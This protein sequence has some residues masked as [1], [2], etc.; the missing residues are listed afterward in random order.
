MPPAASIEAGIAR[1]LKFVEPDSTLLRVWPLTGGI[2]SVMTAFMISRAGDTR[3]LVLRQPGDWS[4]EHVPDVTC[5]EFNRLGALCGGGLPVPAPIFCAPTGAHFGRPGLVLEYI[6]GKP[7]LNPSDPSNY[8]DQFARQLADIHGFDTS[9]QG[10]ALAAAPLHEFARFGVE[11]M[12]QAEPSFQVARSW[13]TLAANA[14]RQSRNTPV[15][16]HGDFWPGNT[17]WRDGALV[18][19]IDWENTRAGD[20]LLDLSISR[21]DI[22]WACGPQAMADFTERY[23]AYHP[24]DTALLPLWDLCTALRPVTNI[25]AWAAAYGPL[26]RPDITADTMRQAHSGFVS[27]AFD[28]W[29]QAGH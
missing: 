14:A 8:V 6:D 12:P 10:L 23:L 16:L 2:S 21:L 24:I 4:L 19:V 15:L 13:A 9:S 29:R 11:T 3:T 22:C 5:R 26:G 18:A 25:E 1:W 20:P 28:A 17:L 27:Q 7:E